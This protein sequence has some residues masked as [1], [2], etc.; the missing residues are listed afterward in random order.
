MKYFGNVYFFEKVTK[1]TDN[2]ENEEYR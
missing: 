1:L 2:Y